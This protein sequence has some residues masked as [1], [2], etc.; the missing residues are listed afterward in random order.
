MENK[1]SKTVDIQLSLLEKKREQL[2]KDIYKFYSIY[3]DCIR[4]N[5]NI[6]IKNGLLSLVNKTSQKV[7]K[8][9]DFVSLLDKEINSLVYEIFPF[10]TVE[11]LSI[12]RDLKDEIELLEINQTLEKVNYEERLFDFPPLINLGDFQNNFTEY[13]YYESNIDEIHSSVNLDNHCTSTKYLTN[14][15]DIYSDYDELNL[16]FPKDNFLYIE[17]N[18]SC[19]GSNALFE[20]GSCFFPKDFSNLI[21]CIE[22]L[23]INLSYYLNKLSYNINLELFKKDYINKIVTEEVFLYF[24]VNNFLVRNP[25]PFVIYI[26][27]PYDEINEKNNFMEN[28][29]NIYLFYI[30]PLELEFSN[31][32]LANLRNKL[33]SFKNELKLLDKK[34]KYWNNR[35]NNF[36][37][38]ST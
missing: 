30:N 26:D 35:K 36:P 23:D 27:I 13:K 8:S 19:E 22:T 15:E 3:L 12:S 5:I 31:I 32:K 37:I 4:D 14:K 17:N 18:L 1:I 34:E 38:S 33:S 9:E 7:I 28:L 25:Q 21:E 11:Q 24:S 20:I 29:H 6:S 2:I 16:G 10:L